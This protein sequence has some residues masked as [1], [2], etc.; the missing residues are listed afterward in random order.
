MEDSRSE[1][2]R[3]AR[4][5]EVKTERRKGN[6]HGSCLQRSWRRTKSAETDLVI[7]EDFQRKTE[8]KI[9]SEEDSGK[10]DTEWQLVKKRKRTKAE[11]RHVFW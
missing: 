8:A 3:K 7:G 9:E 1:A 10:K 11:E 6:V 2:K 4:V 5:E